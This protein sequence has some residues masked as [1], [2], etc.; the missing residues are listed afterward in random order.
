MCKYYEY[1]PWFYDEWESKVVPWEPKF[2]TKRE[3]VANIN[4]A[5]NERY[6]AD[7]ELIY[8]KTIYEEYFGGLPY[9][10]DPLLCFYKGKFGRLEP[11]Y[12][13]VDYKFTELET[14]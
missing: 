9:K 10:G 6:I 13:I 8:I 2:V 12:K 5:I 7:G 3:D 11:V 14:E 4:K 1:G